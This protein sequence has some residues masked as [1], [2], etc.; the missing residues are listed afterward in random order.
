MLIPSPTWASAIRQLST[1]LFAGDSVHAVAASV[2]GVEEVVNI[3]DEFGELRS[4]HQVD[5]KRRRV[6]GY[7]ALAIGIVV[8]PLGVLLVSVTDSSDGAVAQRNAGAVLAIGLVGLVIGALQ[9]NRASRGGRDEYFEVR[10]EGIVHANAFG[11]GGWS[12]DEI[13]AITLTARIRENGLSRALG[14]G[15]RCVVTFSDGARV[16]IDGLAENPQALVRAVRDNC[17]G[18]PVTDGMNGMRRLGTWWLA[19]AAAFLAAGIWMIMTIVTSTSTQ[20]VTDANGSVTET[21]ISH[22]SDS[23]YMLLGIGLLVCAVGLIFSVVMFFTSRAV[24][25]RQRLS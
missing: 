14:T 24:R 18:V 6:T 25:Q 11:V 8:T 15:I 23:G 2:P 19:F 5:N 20:D 21:E 9:L 17:P 3:G 7:W 22:V 1:G 4:K 12:W 13:T 16:R 10:E